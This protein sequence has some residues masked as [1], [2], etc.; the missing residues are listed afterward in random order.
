MHGTGYM[1]FNP[2]AI[3]EAPVADQLL[4]LWG[5][6]A[7]DGADDKQNPP[8]VEFANRLWRFRY[9]STTEANGAT[10]AKLRGAFA[11]P[12]AALATCRAYGLRYVLWGDVDNLRKMPR[13][14]S[15]ILDTAYCPPF[16]GDKV[17][18]VVLDWEVGDERKPA[19]TLAFLKK[20]ASTVPAGKSCLL[21]TNQVG[22][23]GFKE[24]GLEGIGPQLGQAFDGISILQQKNERTLMAQAATFGGWRR[25]CYVTLDLATNNLASAKYVKWLV[26]REG[27]D[28]VNIWRNGADPMTAASRAKL[29]VF[30]QW[31]P[32]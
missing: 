26:E 16:V 17:K 6:H 22:S 7:R 1:T 2:Y 20:F 12:D 18:G 4:F 30:E 23:G 19:P 13:K 32:P 24:S 5:C 15:S 8:E 27:F 11:G 29:A 28:G 14:G 9:S 31:S 10:L 3:R 25:R 21:Y